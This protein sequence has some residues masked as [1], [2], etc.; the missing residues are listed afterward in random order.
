MHPVKTYSNKQIL[1]N[2][3]QTSVEERS[4]LQDFINKSEDPNLR[5]IRGIDLSNPDSITSITEDK[6]G[7]LLELKNSKQFKQFVD[8][9]QLAQKKPSPTMGGIARSWSSNKK[10]PSKN[11]SLPSAEVSIDQQSR[12]G[13]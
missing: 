9:K 2:F 3:C 7:K 8:S 5:D 11:P 6:A 12:E 10:E 4:Y 1:D 13:Q